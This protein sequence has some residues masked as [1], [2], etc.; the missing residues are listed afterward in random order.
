[1]LIALNS[2]QDN[3]LLKSFMANANKVEVIYADMIQQINDIKL[4]KNEYADT[5][6]SEKEEEA[7]KTLNIILSKSTTQRKKLKDIFDALEKDVQIS[8]ESQAEEPET[9]TKQNILVSLKAKLNEITSSFQ[10]ADE[11]FRNVSK[12]KTKRLLKLGI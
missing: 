3:A 7:T 4:L 11:E 9:L 2:D 6:T 5:S 8:K 10:Q 1:M 12:S